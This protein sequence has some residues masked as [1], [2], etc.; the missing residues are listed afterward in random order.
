MKEAGKT[1]IGMYN[2]IN[3]YLSS[4]KVGAPM[5]NGWERKY[6][7]V[8]E[9]LE[10]ADG[11]LSFKIRVLED[12]QIWLSARMPP[13]YDFG[14][15]IRN[16]DERID[17]IERFGIEFDIGHYLPNMVPPEAA[18]I[19]GG[20]ARDLGGSALRESNDLTF[21][22]EYMFPQGLL[23]KFEAESHREGDVS[24]LKVRLPPLHLQVDKVAKLAD[25][26]YLPSDF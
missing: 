14:A 13:I 26:L 22:G 16:Q 9:Q 4:M 5:P 21:W 23:M 20:F 6:G 25:A 19:I 12:G 18:E 2:T 11:P 3:S 17:E 8:E 15:K 7:E 24:F 10:S 1:M